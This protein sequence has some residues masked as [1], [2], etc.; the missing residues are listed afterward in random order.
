MDFCSGTNLL[1]KSRN[2]EHFGCYIK[3]F[4]KDPGIFFI[5]PFIVPLMNKN[6]GCDIKFYVKCFYIEREGD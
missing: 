1:P 5:W 2:I 6:K 3:N 4:L